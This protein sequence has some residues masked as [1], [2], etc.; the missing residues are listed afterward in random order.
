MNRV[1]LRVA[2]LMAALSS[3]ALSGCAAEAAPAWR[4][5]TLDEFALNAAFPSADP[6]CALRSGERTYGFEQVLG[7]TCPDPQARR[8]LSI[9]AQFNNDRR[10]WD[11]LARIAC[12]AGSAPAPFTVQV[13]QDAGRVVACVPANA[14]PDTV[15]VTFLAMPR[16]RNQLFTYDGPALIY[17]M[18]LTTDRTRQ[19]GDLRVFGEFL[20]R[21]TLQGAQLTVD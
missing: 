13:R 10:S 20:R 17:T 16:T 15:A 1:S 14:A 7:G 21:V 19:R 6:V 3:V 4:T 12:P 18:E 8:R 11:E 2:C 9:A 5:G